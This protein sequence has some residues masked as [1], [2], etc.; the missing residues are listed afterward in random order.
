MARLRFK[1]SSS[2]DLAGYRIRIR[3]PNTPPAFDAPYEDIPLTAVSVDE[4]G[5]SRID[6]LGLQQMQGVDGRVDIHLTAIDDA[7]PP[8]ESG[9]LEVDNEDFDFSPP[10][11][12]SEG[13][14]ER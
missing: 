9:F 13:S 10:E 1:G 8:N 11:A 3:P 14:V 7:T 5:V 4:E 12:P 6:L 2:A